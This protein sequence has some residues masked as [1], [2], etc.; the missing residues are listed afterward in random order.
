MVGLSVGIRPAMNTIFAGE[1]S[2]H[3]SIVHGI[4]M[5][6]APG[7]VMLLKLALF[8]MLRRRLL[9]CQVVVSPDTGGQ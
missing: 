7:V 8:L 9:A 2:G 4:N 5:D 3:L 1:G 6:S